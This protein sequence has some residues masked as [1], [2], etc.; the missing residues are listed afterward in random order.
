MRIRIFSTERSHY[1][2]HDD[3]NNNN[4]S[5]CDGSSEETASTGKVLS[6]HHLPRCVVGCPADVAMHSADLRETLCSD[7]AIEGFLNVE[8]L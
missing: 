6:P 5:C 3:D 8:P 4:K 2:M 1:A 7:V